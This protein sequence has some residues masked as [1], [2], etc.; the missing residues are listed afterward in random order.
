V[1]VVPGGG[2]MG[3]WYSTVSQKL[4]S[5]AFVDNVKNIQSEIGTIGLLKAPPADHSNRSRKI[6]FIIL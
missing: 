2:G 3:E 4:A 1:N 5:V 6:F